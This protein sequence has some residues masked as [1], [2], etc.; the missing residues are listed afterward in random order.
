MFCLSFS[1][2][3]LSGALSGYG[4][5]SRKSSATHSCQCVQYFRVS[6]NDMAISVWG[7][8]TYA[9]MMMHAIAHDACTDTVRQPKL[10]AN[11]RR[12]NFL[13]R[14]ESNPHQYSA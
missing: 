14:R 12:S 10:I 1:S 3:S 2:T 13:S 5:S 9:Q 7:I 11:S 4:Y 6:D 8:V